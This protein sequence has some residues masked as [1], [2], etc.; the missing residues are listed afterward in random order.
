MHPG[1]VERGGGHDLSPGGG[2]GCLWGGGCILGLGSP[3]GA[4]GLYLCRCGSHTEMNNPP[5][6]FFC[7]CD[8]CHISVY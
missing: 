4:S 5:D 2:R 3:G 1:S 8:S 6:I 7:S